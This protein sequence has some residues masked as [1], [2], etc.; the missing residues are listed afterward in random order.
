MLKHLYLIICNLFELK[1]DLTR[2]QCCI[3][4]LYPYQREL[5]GFFR[6]RS[7]FSSTFMLLRIIYFSFS[8]YLE[9]FCSANLHCSNKNVLRLNGVEYKSIISRYNI[10]SH[11]LCRFYSTGSAYESFNE[12]VIYLIILYRATYRFR[13]RSH[14]KD[15]LCM[16]YSILNVQLVVVVAAF[17]LSV[18]LSLI[19]PNPD[20]RHNAFIK[21]WCLI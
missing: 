15:V 14:S 18:S 17:F 13:L 5:V 7:L 9:V 3:Q 19:Q 10:F 20:W 1:M 11:F 8:S 12:F 2:R 6:K 16:F 21:A 4:I